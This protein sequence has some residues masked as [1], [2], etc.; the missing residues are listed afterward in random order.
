MSHLLRHGDRHQRG[1]ALVLQ[2]G[3]VSEDHTEGSP[4]AVPVPPDAV[5]AGQSCCVRKSI[6]AADTS[7]HVHSFINRRNP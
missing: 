7:S 2:I 1:N 5:A 3:E 4:V 6:C